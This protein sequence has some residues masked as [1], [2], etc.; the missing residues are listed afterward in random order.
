ML[1][2]K[3]G[4][5]DPLAELVLAGVAFAR[6]RPETAIAHLDSAERLAK[7]ERMAMFRA[8]ASWQ[9]GQLVGGSEGLAMIAE[10]ESHMKAEGVKRPP[11][12]A[13]ML[14]PGFA[15]ETTLGRPRFVLP[16]RR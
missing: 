8:A 15:R 13:A 9:R 16:P 4:W 12:M 3:A 7:E 11:Q 5:A 6:E 14:A 1:Q 10:A 2:A